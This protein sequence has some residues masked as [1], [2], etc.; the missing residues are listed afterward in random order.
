MKLSHITPT[1]VDEI[2]RVIDPGKLYICCQYRAIKHLC[3]CGC[4]VA[5]NTPLHPTAWTLTCDGV[6]VSLNP[7]IGNWSEK[8]LSHYWIKQNN[9]HWAPKLSRHKI[10][11]VRKV[12]DLEREQYYNIGGHPET[13]DAGARLRII[14]TSIRRCF[15]RVWGRFFSRR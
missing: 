10:Q 8:C 14:V 2:P 7:S 3:A 4:G 1:F 9:I 13:S 15:R 12:R 6:S 5:I 11:Q